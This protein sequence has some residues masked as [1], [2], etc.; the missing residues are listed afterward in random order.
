MLQDVLHQQYPKSEQIKITE[1]SSDSQ[2]KQQQYP[3]MQWDPEFRTL[4]LTC[5]SHDLLRVSPISNVPKPYILNHGSPF[6]GK[7]HL[8]ELSLK[9]L[10]SIPWQRI[11]AAL[12]SQKDQRFGFSI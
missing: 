3:R 9:Q 5:Q 10:P 2:E 8:K 1:H 11:A 12:G 7:S 6:L 4:N